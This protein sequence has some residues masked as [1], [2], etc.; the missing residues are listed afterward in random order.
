MNKLKIFCFILLIEILSSILL[1]QNFGS[2]EEDFAKCRN[3]NDTK[4]CA[5]IIF[6]NNNFQCCNLKSKEKDLEMCNAMLKPIKPAQEELATEN[7]KKM[8][9]EIGGYSLFSNGSAVMFNDYYFTCPDGEANFKFDPNAYT[10][11]EK[12]K[13]KSDNHC[14]YYSSREYPHEKITE[15]ICYNAILS[16]TENSTISCGYYELKL[17]FKDGS[18]G[19]YKSCFLFNDD[20]LSTK[21]LG[22]WTKTTAEEMAIEAEYKEDKKYSNYQFNATNSKGE[23]FIYYSINDTVIVPSDI[24]PTD[25]DIPTDTDEPTDTDK[26]SDTDEPSDSGHNKSRF[27]NNGIIFLLS[28]FLF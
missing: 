6:E 15:E 1:E 12:A 22:L 17:N 25:T 13:F 7:G 8:T 5:S 26:P 20:I 16:T 10:E 9:K 18:T 3:F 11:E 24:D 28:L 2:T 4:Q 14:L 19:I 23:Y 27:L 21:N